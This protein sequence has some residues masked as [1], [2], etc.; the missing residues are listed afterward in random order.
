MA[1]N[2][3]WLS[4]LR[5]D[6]TSTRW[7]F[8][9]MSCGDRESH[10]GV[11]EMENNRTR[12]SAIMLVLLM[13]FST[14]AYA[15]TTTTFSDGSS[16]AVIEVREALTYSNADD[17]TVSL[18]AGDT[19]TSASMKVGTAMA[20]HSQVTTF[21]SSNNPD[22]WDPSYNNQRTTYSN[23][24]DFTYTEKSL[25][26]VTDGFTTD[27]E[28][29]ASGFSSSTT[30]PATGSFEH[31]I[32]AN[33]NSIDL[34][35]NSGDS[36]WGSNAFDDYYPDDAAEGV[37]NFDFEMLS[38]GMWVSP[39]G[40]I[41][42]FS[43]FHSLFYNN[44]GTTSNP[45][46][47]MYDCAYVQYDTSSNGIDWSGAWQHI[48]FDMTN[49][50]GVSY[51]NGIYPIGVGNNKIQTCDGVPTGSYAL[52]GTSVHPQLNVNGWGTLALN[53]QG[54]INKY[55]RF[56]FVLE[57][58]DNFD[59]T[60]EEPFLPGWYIDDFRL[61]DLLPQSGT[62][63]VEGFSSSLSMGQ[64]GF[65]D[66][67]GI[68]SLESVTSPT[69]SLTVD[70]LNA[71]GTEVVVDNNNQTLLGLEGDMIELWDINT[72]L[73][74]QI[75][76]RFNFDSGLYRLSTPELHAI[77]LGSRIGT[78][79]NDTT[80]A[81]ASP[82]AS[83]G[84]WM[85]SGVMG[86]MVMYFPTV[87]DNSISPPALKSSYRQPITGITPVVTDDC[88]DD[89]SMELNVGGGAPV[90]VTPGQMWTPS[91]PIFS[92]VS[93]LSYSVPCTVTG[94]WFD[95]QFGFS[96]ST[97]RIDIAGDGDY[98]WGFDEPAFAHFGMQ[99]KY[100]NNK[101]DGINM[102]TDTSTLTIGPSGTGIGGTFMMPKGAT[103][104]AAEFALDQNTIYSNSNQ[105]EGFS[106]NLMSGTQEEY[107]GDWENVSTWSSDGF[108]IPEVDLK[109]SMNSLL[110]NPMVPTSHIDAY[111]NEWISFHFKA[112]S[113]NASTGASMR[114]QNLIVLYDWSVELGAQHNL[115]REL[116]QGI[117]LGTES[118]GMVS[119]PFE[120]QATSGGALSMHD[121][122]V[123]SSSGY[124][125]SLTLTDSP[126]GLYPDGG[127]IEAVSQHAVD[128]STGASFDQARLRIESTSGSIELGYSNLMGF[129]EV[130]DPEDLIT[131]Q[132]SSATD[133][134]GAK[135]ISWRFTINPSWE[136]SLE[137]RVFA[138]LIA[139]NGV[140]GM[141]GAIALAPS[142]GNAIEND[143]GITE[144]DV[145]NSAGESQSLSDGRSNQLIRLVGS[146]K[147]EGL[148]AAPD[149]ASYRILMEVL[150]I[151][152]TDPQN[153]TYTWIEVDNASGPIGGDFDWLVDLGEDA[154]GTE[155]YRFRMA[156]YT[157]GDTL[158]PPGEYF[159]GPECEIQFQLTIDTYSPSLNDTQV[160]DGSA[161]PGNAGGYWRPLY[162]DT[163]V[164]PSQTQW[165]KFTAQDI[166]DPPETLTLNYWVQKDHDVDEDGIPHESEYLQVTLQGDGAAPVANYTG[167]INDIANDGHD[168]RVSLFVSGNDLAGNS[169]VAGSPGLDNDLISY[170]GMGSRNP[171]IESFKIRDTF[172]NEFDTTTKTMF[173][174]NEYHLIVEGRDDNGWRD[175]SSFEI[176]LNPGVPDDMVLTYYPRT[177]TVVTDSL[178]IEVVEASNDSNGTQMVRR[179]GQSLID[180]FET[181]FMLDMPIKI[182]WNCPTA[183]GVM[184]PQVRV[185]DLDPNNPS[186]VLTESGGRYKQ[187][188][189]Y[190]DGFLLDT[191]SLNLE[192]MTGPFIT[193]NIYNFGSGSSADYVYSGDTVQFTGQYAF[194]D[195]YPSVVVNPEITMTM[196]VTRQDA[197][198]DSSGNEQ[199]SGEIT[200]HEFSGGVFAINLTAPSKTNE[201]HYTFN[202]D[203]SSLPEGAVDHT[204][205]TQ[206]FKIKVDSTAPEILANTWQATDTK[207]ATLGD[208]IMP[209]SSIHCVDVQLMVKETER[210]DPHSI[211]V[212]WMF[213]QNGENWSFAE[214]NY[215]GAQSKNLSLVGGGDQIIAESAECIDLWP[216]GHELPSKEQLQN[217][218]LRF[219]VTGHDSAGLGLSGGG[220][221]TNP[222]RG[223]QDQWTSEYEVVYEQAEF[224]ITQFKMFPNAPEVGEKVQLD[225]TVRNDG[226]TAG[227]LEMKIEVV[228]ASD[229]ARATVKIITTPSIGV[230]DG[231]LGSNSHNMEVDIEAFREAKANL[232]FEIT[233]NA[234]GEL[235]YTSI[236]SGQTYDI[237]L[238]TSVDDSLPV[239]LILAVLGGLIGILVIVVVVLVLRGRSEGEYDELEYGDDKAYPTIPYEAQQGYGGG[240]EEAY[241]G[242]GYDH[243][244]GGYGGYGATGGGVTPEM[245]QALA[246][247]P[248]WDQQT[249]QGYFD[250]GWSVEQ[251]RDWVRNQG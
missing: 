127:I 208:G 79:L 215:G 75:Q 30:P 110:S 196:I 20:N 123:V 83:E 195:G 105:T 129:W 190:G 248:Q 193:S 212:H 69:N 44:T 217:V 104:L 199:L 231:V 128:A 200:Y 213:F 165:F 3:F 247:F 66:G 232:H 132:S 116:S 98:E 235:I 251:L 58:N 97:V 194:K 119:V 35:C 80:S 130:E 250:M 163:W 53:L 114:L 137:A 1:F 214:A 237:S 4:A 24:D 158:C 113:P 37:N 41:A 93:Q 89:P 77:H 48:D 222:I 239:G 191:T 168:G 56:R 63:I 198:A 183:T 18:P 169:I 94:L 16:E 230:F 15:A 238:A 122:M 138:S 46:H 72:S 154:A 32:L 207:G 177:H 182:D 246:E 117:A 120:M 192:D 139:D 64:P 226:N 131:L 240:G 51:S 164:S 5:A 90:S 171:G 152:S 21:D 68:L 23:I 115:V 14:T 27:F 2:L 211:Y 45:S 62:V 60:P 189:I 206:E 242:G 65:P 216:D 8:M 150:D 176:D 26:L 126:F 87:T 47:Y 224:A 101:V 108:N 81:I 174:G 173:A 55:A 134:L 179:N 243:A 29:T 133:I 10:C 225:I 244:G 201:F 100:W 36:C 92:F 40:Y 7:V 112:Q 86:E 161:A 57:R 96:P 109:S 202:V 159:P 6:T 49:S 22:I 229:G 157:G 73:Y 25:S 91:E 39:T 160:W 43:S 28:G 95:L 76:L 205:A 33:Q 180:P 50:S 142:T 249:I 141:P 228:S 136:D 162:D 155:E 125:S 12:F 34:D 227:T 146:I 166:P 88:S 52:G 85:T 78:G 71:Q 145:Q 223:T 124:S 42:K 233:N 11:T 220:S 170:V 147:L 221:D 118:G 236:N 31:A 67:F 9:L 241:G 175:I 148:E 82:P 218:I 107:L 61:G 106:M 197:S 135:E 59:K 144:F 156:W 84:E 111:G 102:A 17:G 184:T 187:R 19:V 54:A 245:Q 186:S 149:P 140:E 219:W 209:S 153:I 172:G 188:W 13:L 103:V 151:N 167:T 70:I 203:S 181:E 185:K 38:P 99:D 210:L 74:P 204:T 143:A 234:T 121:L 178:W